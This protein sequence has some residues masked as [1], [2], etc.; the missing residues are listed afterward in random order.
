[1]DNVETNSIAKKFRFFGKKRK[2]KTKMEIL[3]CYYRK[4]VTF[5]F[6]C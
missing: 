4:L 2:L 3:F 5:V 6:D 1:M